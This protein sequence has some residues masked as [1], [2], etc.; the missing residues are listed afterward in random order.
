MGICGST[1]SEG[2]WPKAAQRD[3]ALKWSYEFKPHPKKPKNKIRDPGHYKAKGLRGDMWARGPGSIN[4]DQ[5]QVEDCEDCD[6]F[7]CDEMD[8]LVVD[9]CKN[10]RFF[11]GPT[12]GSAFL[13][14]SSNCKVVI[15]C[16]QLRLRECKDMDFAIFCNSKPV[17]ES[18]KRI[19]FCCFDG[20]YFN[21]KEQFDATKMSV[22]NN[23][24]SEIHDFTPQSNN[25]SY[26]EPTLRLLD[27]VNPL[28]TGIPDLITAEEESNPHKEM[29]VPLTLGMRPLM[30]SGE[31]GFVLFFPNQVDACNTFL[32]LC[33]ENAVAITQTKEWVIPFMVAPEIFSQSPNVPE[34]RMLVSGPS[35]SVGFFGPRATEDVLRLLEPVPVGAYYAAQSAVEA[36]HL[37]DQVFDRHALGADFKS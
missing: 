9:D 23:R 28:S 21:L 6:F 24:W 27:F 32:W 20:Y 19:T 35:I 13:R 8:S 10:C 25:W 33:K 3:V 36:K 34:K 29:V 16:G 22:F 11:V 31:F 15:A 17:I 14:T 26:S 30:T 12:S 37:H 2:K 1:D 4:G 18:S 5:I 7:L